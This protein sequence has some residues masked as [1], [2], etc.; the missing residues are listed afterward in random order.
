MIKKLLISAITMAILAGSLASANAATDVTNGEVYAKIDADQI[1]LG[2]SVIERVWATSPFHTLSM[3]DKRTGLVTGELASDFTLSYHGGTEVGQFGDL[4]QFSTD[5]LDFKSASAT[6]LENGGVELRVTMTEGNTGVGEVVRTIRAFPG[7]AGFETQM[8]TSI[9]GALSAYTLDRVGV[10]GAAT[11]I[12]AF[13]AG[14][15]WRG[16]DST[17]WEPAAQPFGGA[18]LGDHRETKSGA[19]GQSLEGEGEWMSL[20]TP[21]GRAFMVTQ[22]VDYA[23]TRMSYTDPSASAEVDLD[24]DLIYLGPFESDIHL[25]NDVN[26]VPVR[27]RVIAPGQTL[28]LEPVF[29]G[30]AIDADDEPWQHY[31]YLTEHRMPNWKR[32]VTFNSNNVDAGRIS[33]GAKDD[34]DLAAVREQSEIAKRLG[35]ETFILDDGWQAASGDFCP[36]SPECP[37]PRGL[38]PAR[39]PDGSFSAVRNILG[40]MKLGLWMNPMQF[41]PASNAYK[42][43]P[44]WN[45]EPISEPL[46]AYN[47]VDPN[48]GSNEAGLGTWNPEAT[49]PEGKLIDFIE[50]RIR[51][52]I[53]NWGVTYFKFDFLAWVD[54]AG[55][56][57]VT[58]YDYRES[59][60]RMMDRLIA[61]HPNVTFQIDETNDYRLFPFESVARGPSWY[62]NGSPKSNEALHNL[63]VLNPYVPGFTLGQATLGGQRGQLSNDYLMA[64][65]L[66]SHMT[67]FTNLTSLSEQQITDA[68]RWTDLYK[69]HRDRFAT[70]TYPLLGDPLPGDNWT[71]L[72][73]WNPETGT[74]AL[75]AFRQ[76][77]DEVAKTISLRGI[78]GDGSFVLRD[79]L[80][81]EVFGTFTAEQLRSGIEISLPDKHSAR[82]LFIDPAV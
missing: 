59:F 4:A 73:P 19:P 79:A 58:A 61:D 56:D 1:V 46:V 28:A 55:V 66:G 50:G 39:F 48:G 21:Q 30:L 70:F 76:D 49:G 53:D 63:W 10:E 78:R 37:E 43:N 14:Y 5:D 60:I 74:G 16:S 32:D 42:R 77:T 71:A 45:C 81:D 41:N 6:P 25:G 35:V 2:N 15:D 47:R 62:A 40:D 82:V 11:E 3:T 22:R 31:R 36:D 8:T 26:Q 51:N 9:P 7:I 44:Q 67:F 33:T 68:R 72:Q 23:S 20:S 69:A 54:C 57:T 24:H 65:A 29:T 12:H 17:D 27:Y 13:S 18:H 64:I 75:L 34:M 52:A 38:Y 80:T